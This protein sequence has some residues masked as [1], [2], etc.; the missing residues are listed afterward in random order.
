MSIK[1]FLGLNRLRP[2]TDIAVF[3]RYIT[4][5]LGKPLPT[6][7]TLEMMPSMA[8]STSTSNALMMLTKPSVAWVISMSGEMA[9]KI[10]EFFANSDA[11]LSVSFCYSFLINRKWAGH[12]CQ[13]LQFHNS[14]IF[15]EQTIPSSH[16]DGWRAK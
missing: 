7:L 10:A 9:S 11:S 14:I 5:L 12:F 15:A 2:L 6:S 13:P 4:V 8:S 16:R 1:S 3:L